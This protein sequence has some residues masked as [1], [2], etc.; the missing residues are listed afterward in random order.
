MHNTAISFAFL[1][2]TLGLTACTVAQ[3]VEPGEEALGEGDEVTG[4]SRQALVDVAPFTARYDGSFG[5]TG[6]C[7]AD[8]GIH[9]YAP[10]APGQYPVFIYTVGTFGQYDATEADTIVREM[11]GRGFIAASIEYANG[12][13]GSCDRLRNKA[14]CAYDPL[15]GASAVGRLCGRADADCWR[16]IVVGGM[17]Q[18]SSMALLAKNHDWRVRAAW[19]MG[20]TDA[21]GVTAACVDNGF[22]LLP[23]DRVRAVSGERD[24]YAN[25][26]TLELITGSFCAAGEQS[27]LRPNGSGW[28]RVRDSQVQDGKADH[29]YYTTS[30]CTNEPILDIGWAP[31]ASAPWSLDTN[32][33]WLAQFADP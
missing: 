6:A 3:G 28:Y 30:G 9:G 22:R 10:T 18:G 25:Q 29:C 2:S 13:G 5:A 16:G 11:A 33:D 20:A 24:I 32:L 8:L 26:L 7:I 19:V 21:F 31:P 1:V 15:S 27:C 14:S 17:S 4:E 12:P 23:G